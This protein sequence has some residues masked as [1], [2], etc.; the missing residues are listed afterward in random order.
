MIFNEGAFERHFLVGPQNHW[1]Q[2]LGTFSWS[3]L[4]NVVDNFGDNFEDKIRKISGAISGTISG[5]I[6]GTI[7]EQ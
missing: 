4:F 6:W 7:S 2:I 1:G 5:T 3:I